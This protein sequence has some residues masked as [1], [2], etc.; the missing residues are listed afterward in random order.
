MG[1]QAEQKQRHDAHSRDRE[2]D[3]GES[4][5][6]RNLREGP[7]WLSGTIIERTGPASYRVQ[8]RDQL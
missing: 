7:K 8:V 6:A 2:F 1:K 4:V 3:S 5:L